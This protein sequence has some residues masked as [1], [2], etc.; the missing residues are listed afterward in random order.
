VDQV[1]NAIAVL[2]IY[3]AMMAVLA[4]AVEAV[5][6][7]FKVPIPWLQGKP[8]PNDV[9]NEVKDWIPKEADSLKARITALNKSLRAIGDIELKDDTSIEDVVAK[10]GEATT[11]HVQKERVRRAIIRVM[12]IALGVLFAWLFNVDTL[13]LLSPLFEAVQGT[14][15]ET[16]LNAQGAH[17]IGLLLSGLAAS[18]G[19]SFWHDQSAR[20][21]QIKVASESA[22][23]LVGDRG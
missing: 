5:I 2:G 7:W 6:S 20:L 21:R 13:S 9:L 12:A 19:S 15:K 17:L 23:E 16:L 22:G 10:V 11:K 3:F 1:A 4:V 8:S 14:L 18:A